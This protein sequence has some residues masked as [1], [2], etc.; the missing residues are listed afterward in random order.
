MGRYYSGDI[1]GKFWFGVQS[2]DDA[3]FF[4]RRGHAY[5]L[6]YYYDEDSMKGVEKGI[7]ECKDNLG[8]WYGKLDKFFK[9]NNGYNKEMIKE[10][11]DMPEDKI[12]YYLEWYARLKLGVKI[13]SC[14]KKDGSCSFQAEL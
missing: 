4:G 9:N 13:R 12:S 8:V 3:D 5:Y 1:E 2:S 14:L 7:S 11:I 10:Q 6:D